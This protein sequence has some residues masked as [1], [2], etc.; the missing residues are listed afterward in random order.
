MSQFILLQT[1]VGS[2][3][4]TYIAACNGRQLSLEEAQAADLVDKSA[5]Q[6]HAQSSYTSEWFEVEPGDQVFLTIQEDEG[7][8]EERA[9][10]TFTVPPQ[11]LNNPPTS[12]DDDRLGLWQHEYYEQECRS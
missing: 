1:Y 7:R 11:G 5:L 8:F 12:L 4:F 6:R 2:S 3:D 10:L 9:T